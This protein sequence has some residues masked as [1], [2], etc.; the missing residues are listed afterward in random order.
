[1]LH[2]TETLDRD[3]LAA[4]Q[5]FYARTK[6][7]IS[8]PKMNLVENNNRQKLTILLI[9]IALLSLFQSIIITDFLNVISQTLRYAMTKIINK[10]TLTS[11][12]L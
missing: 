8:K 12:R 3:Y 2:T 9:L 5:D 6:N 7:F 11:T 4:G 10:P 1:M